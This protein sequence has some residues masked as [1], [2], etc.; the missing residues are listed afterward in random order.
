MASEHR[1]EL[2][3]VIETH[4]A[5]KDA[6]REIHESLQ[7]ALA[8]FG[9]YQFN[10]VVA[11][12]MKMMNTLGKVDGEGAKA[13]RNEGLSILL[14][15]LSPIAPH[16][17]H[18]LW[19]ELGYGDDILTAAWPAVDEAA[20]VKDS[21]E[22]VVQVNGKVRSQI[23]VAANADKDSIEE[24]ALADEKVQSFIDGKTIRKI[25]VVPGRLVN[26]V[27]N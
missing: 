5:S 9:K 6:R 25:I 8:D 18:A 2:G 14:R 19:Q 1:G 27:A 4:D 7:Q 22:L 21:I 10:T 24:A 26:V 13:L 23:N 20:L 15:L 12:C 11:A 16:I 17:S 3:G